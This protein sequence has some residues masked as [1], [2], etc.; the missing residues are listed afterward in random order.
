MF[1]HGLLLS[2]GNIFVPIVAHAVHNTFALV[3]CHL[4]VRF[5]GGVCLG[6]CLWLPAFLKSPPIVRTWSERGGSAVTLPMLCRRC[7][8]PT[9]SGHPYSQ[10]AAS[11]APSTALMLLVRD[12]V[13]LGFFSPLPAVVT[14]VTSRSWKYFIHNA[15]QPPSHA[16]TNV[17]KPNDALFA[18]ACTYFPLQTSRPR[19]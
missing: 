12:I 2:T 17:A 7:L 10:N 8:C 5:L 11:V 9:A 1:F 13:H 6:Q 19:S 4:K 15:A 3:L 14:R 16:D 18:P